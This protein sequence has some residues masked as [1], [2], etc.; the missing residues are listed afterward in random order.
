MG[1]TRRETHP[2]GI[3]G[4]SLVA[5]RCCRPGNIR[6][7]QRSV[8]L[9][10]QIAGWQEDLGGDMDVPRREGVSRPA[11]SSL[12]T[13]SAGSPTY[14]KLDLLKLMYLSREGDRREGILFRQGQGWFQIGP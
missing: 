2:L 13:Q 6:R 14:N 1:E 8:G 7:P 12:T 3:H 10:R 5:I 4:P 11:K 9:S